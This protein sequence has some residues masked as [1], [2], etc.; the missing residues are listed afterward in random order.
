MRPLLASLI[1][2]TTERIFTSICEIAALDGYAG[3]RLGQCLSGSSLKGRILMAW[4]LVLKA[5]WMFDHGGATA[6]DSSMAKAGAASIASEVSQ[7]AASIL[8]I[9]QAD[10]DRSLERF[11]RNAKAFD[12]LEGTGDMQRLMIAKLLGPSGRKLTF[13]GDSKPVEQ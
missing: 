7:L 12:I 11:I 2:G 8:P 10:P 4:H 13:Q 3:R 5:A 6:I 1:V 9:L